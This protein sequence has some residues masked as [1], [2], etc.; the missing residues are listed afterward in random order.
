LT[1]ECNKSIT[2]NVTNANEKTIDSETNTSTGDDEEYGVFLY[3]TKSKTIP[4]YGTPD[5]DYYHYPDEIPSYVNEHIYT[6]QNG[7]GLLDDGTYLATHYNIY[8]W[9]GGDLRDA[10]MDNAVLAFYYSSKD[11]L[12]YY[13]FY[14]DK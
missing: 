4:K 13:D 2:M 7:H 14:K 8:V 3:L 9:M 12:K 1:N 5:S 6:L 11:W 10:G